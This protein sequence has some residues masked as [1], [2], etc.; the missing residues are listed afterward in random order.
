MTHRSPDSVTSEHCKG[1]LRDASVCNVAVLLAPLVIDDRL[2]FLLIVDG[3]NDTRQRTQDPPLPESLPS[4]YEYFFFPCSL[5]LRVRP[6]SLFSPC[7]CAAPQKGTR[8]P[9][10]R[11]D[12]GHPRLSL[13]CYPPQALLPIGGRHA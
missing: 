9:P 6:S 12:D 3:W 10:S 5:L 4:N 7:F 13:V 11:S 1:A 2:S 8:P